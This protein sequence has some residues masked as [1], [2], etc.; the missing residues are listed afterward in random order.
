MD[1]NKM[2][3]TRAHDDSNRID[4]NNRNATLLLFH[5]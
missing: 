5:V 1:S 2:D 4:K 3:G